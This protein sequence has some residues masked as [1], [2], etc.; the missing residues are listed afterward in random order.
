MIISKGFILTP[1]SYMSNNWNRLDLLII[2]I[3]ILDIFVS[4]DLS[5]IKILRAIRPIRLISKNIKIKILI[6][7]LI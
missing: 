7:S 1:N 5:F 2:I 4:A 3:S 6:V